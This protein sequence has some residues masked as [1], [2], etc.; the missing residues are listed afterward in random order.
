[1]DDVYKIETYREILSTRSSTTFNHLALLVASLDTGSA[2]LW[3][4][5]MKFDGTVL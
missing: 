5:V 3:E 2:A 1:M 4:W